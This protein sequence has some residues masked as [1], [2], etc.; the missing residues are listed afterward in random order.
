MATQQ[1][2]QQPFA[3]V[4]IKTSPEN[5]WKILTNIENWKEIIWGIENIVIKS[6]DKVGP[7]IEK[8]LIYYSYFDYY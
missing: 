1:Q 3:S 4:S 2:Q 6:E 8:G 5:V 7:F